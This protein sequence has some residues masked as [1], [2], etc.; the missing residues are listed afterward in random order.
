MKVVI[1]GIIFARE[2]VGG[3]SRV[4]EEYL[5]RLPKV[6]EDITLVAPLFSSNVFLKRLIGSTRELSIASDMLHYPKRY[7]ER[8]EFRSK[9]L[10]W[11]HLPKD[12]NIFHTTFFST[13]YTD[14]VKKVVTV[15]DM[16]PELF[17]PQQ[18]D[19][20][21][22]FIVSMKKKVI[23]NADMIIA[24]SDSTKRD[25]LSVYPTI[26]PDRITTI[27]N[28]V[29]TYKPGK[30]PSFSELV[31]KYNL[32]I[33]SNEYYLYVGKRG[34]YNNFELICSLLE[35]FRYDHSDIRFLCLGSRVGR[36][37]LASLRD[38]GLAGR[39]HFVEYVDESEMPTFY[40]N[41]RAL[42]YPS[43]YEGFG[44]PILEAN[45]N[46]CPVICS[47]I[48]AFREVA[49]D[50][51]IYFDPGS[52]QSLSAAIGELNEKPRSVMIAAGLDN[53]SRFSWDRAVEH[54]WAVYQEVLGQH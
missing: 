22:H 34:G 45:V 51:A 40:Q 9:N 48:P 2:K 32:P 28:G 25:I 38:R 46:R 4:W 21:T 20:W 23:E 37:E 43:K 31:A 26:S 10:E 11:F 18:R 6:C 15:H 33:T 17:H 50:S 13:V 7:F 12:A 5:Q 19:Q 27:H 30:S 41:A 14:R 1:D 52:V 16:I 29:T 8:V 53:V 24:V 42:V 36:N 35:L 44:I 49:G 47:D 54:L 39:F 3:I